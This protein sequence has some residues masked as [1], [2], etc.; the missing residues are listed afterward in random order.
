MPR[1]A[2]IPARMLLLVRRSAVVG[3]LAL[4]Y[5]FHRVIGAAYPLTTIG[6][7][8]FAAVAQ[9]APALFGAILWRRGNRAGAI[10][11]IAAG[12]AVWAYTAL[13]PSVAD[14]GWIDAGLLIHG[15]LGI[16]WLNPR[17]LLGWPGP[18]P[19]THSVMWS[20]GLNLA[21]YVGLSLAMP[22]AGDRAAA[23]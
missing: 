9:F 10:G 19:L 1:G 13:L 8:S 22:P 4:A 14:A 6:L 11:G 12:F 18:D 2:T 16:G 21:C 3:I 23:G 15:P 7:V 5:G 20:L 17:A